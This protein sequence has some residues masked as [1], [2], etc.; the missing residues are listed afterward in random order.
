M[1]KLHR[2]NDYCLIILFVPSAYISTL[3]PPFSRLTL[4]LMLSLS[5]SSNLSGFSL[6]IGKMVS[7]STISNTFDLLPPWHGHQ[8]EDTHIKAHQAVWCNWKYCP[9]E[10][11]QSGMLHW[12]IT[13]L[14]IKKTGE[15]NVEKLFYFIWRQGGQRLWKT[16]ERVFHH[17]RYYGTRRGEIIPTP[18]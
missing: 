14:D 10:T 3:M 16:S 13:C 7:G 4:P 5:N 12:L 2:N 15:Y 1:E 6:W 8:N 9:P 17:G 11:I 18:A